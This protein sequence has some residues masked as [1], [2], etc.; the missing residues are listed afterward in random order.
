[1]P[2]LREGSYTEAMAD[3]ESDRDW[4]GSCREGG[5]EQGVCGGG[6]RGGGKAGSAVDLEGG[7]YRESVYWVKHLQFWKLCS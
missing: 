5:G 6:G 2:E 7:K 4:G 1:M 3:R